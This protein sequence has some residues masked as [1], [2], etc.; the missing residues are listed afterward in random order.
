MPKII[1]LALS[2]FNTEFSRIL[3]KPRLSALTFSV[4]CDKINM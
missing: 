2:V 3:K 4:I 1:K